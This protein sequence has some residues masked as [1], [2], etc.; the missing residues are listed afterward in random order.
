[1][2]TALNRGRFCLYSCSSVCL[3]LLHGVQH[4]R[5]EVEIRDGDK[6]KK[7]KKDGDYVFVFFVVFKVCTLPITFLLSDTKTTKNVIINVFLLV[8]IRTLV[9][10]LECFKYLLRLNKSKDFNNWFRIKSS[11]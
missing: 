8:M 3:L 6:K 1:M 4:F 2:K 11:G 7:G 10:S 9:T 5:L